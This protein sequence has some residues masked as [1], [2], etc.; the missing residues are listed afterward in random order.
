MRY[1]APAALVVLAVAVV[2]VVVTGSSAGTHHTS[3]PSVDSRGHRGHRLHRF[4]HVHAGDTLSRVALKTGV[5]LS[6][7]ESLN[8]GLDPSTLHPHQR[9]RLRP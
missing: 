4:Y 1:L 7:I 6:K 2:V 8:P 3:T 9:I 5:P